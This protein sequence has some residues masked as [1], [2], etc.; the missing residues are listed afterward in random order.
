M[1]S[2]ISVLYSL[3]SSITLS[4][5]DKEIYG[6]IL[7]SV[8]GAILGAFGAFLVGNHTREKEIAN[9]KI[10]ENKITVKNDGFASE[11]INN[12]VIRILFKNALNEKIAEDVGKGILSSPEQKVVFQINTPVVYP[13][14]PDSLKDL[15]N[16]EIR[17]LC[18]TLR[19]EIDLQ[20]Q[21]IDN[22][23]KYYQEIRTTVVGETL[24][25]N[26]GQLNRDSLLSDHRMITSAMKQQQNANKT[27]RIKCLKILGTFRCYNDFYNSNIKHLRD[28]NNLS[29]H[30]EVIE[31][32]IVYKPSKDEQDRGIKVS[33]KLFDKSKLINQPLSK[34]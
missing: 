11:Q 2:S 5:T 24:R 27:L 23:N 9:Q 31:K 21:G 32:L 17:L 12:F 20:N 33:D 16:N 18:D 30:R 8:L 22:F 7:G 19:E 4:D 25:G 13:Q 6:A 3:L 34:N 15:L 14:I 26:H 10:K 28:S 1:M 29:E